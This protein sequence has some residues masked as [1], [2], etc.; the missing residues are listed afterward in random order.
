MISSGFSESI[1]AVRGGQPLLWFYCVLL[2]H[3]V[4]SSQQPIVSCWL[5]FF[6]LVP[7]FF[8][9]RF[10][11]CVCSLVFSC[12]FKSAD[13]VDLGASSVSW[14]IKPQTSESPRTGRWPSA[15]PMINGSDCAY[16][17]FIR[18][19]RPTDWILALI[20]PPTLICLYGA[21]IYSA[22]EWDRE[23][24]PGSIHRHNST[25]LMEERIKNTSRCVVDFMSRWL[26]EI[27][28]AEL[29]LLHSIKKRLVDGNKRIQPNQVSRLRF[30]WLL[31]SSIDF[32]RFERDS[33]KISQ[34]FTP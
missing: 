1:N 5:R 12:S 31:S 27:A 34:D 20:L 24:R 32:Y 8:V 16:L 21:L 10:R 19:Q 23:H 17:G 26:D 22:D 11:F 13:V 6:S 3:F 4:T 33:Y 14:L 2:S 30:H 9:W 15:H 18:D 25:I 28:I 29:T 7:F